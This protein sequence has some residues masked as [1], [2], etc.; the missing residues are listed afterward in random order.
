MTKLKIAIIDLLGLTY[1]GSTLKKRGLGG[2]ES[3]VILMAEQLSGVGFDVTVFNNCIDSEAE[4]GFYLNGLKY[5][6]HGIDT[7]SIPEYIDHS[8]YEDEDCGEEC[9]CFDIVISSRSVH[10]FFPN[11]QYQPLIKK[12]KYK[13]IWMHDTFCEGD[14][15]IENML[16]QGIIDELFTL[17]DFHSTY[18]LNCDHGGKRNFEVMKHK[19]FQTRNGAVK[20]IDEIDLS[21]KDKNHF[22]YNA[23]VT[24]GLNP[25]L[26][27]I[28]PEVKRQIPNAHLTVIGGFYRF[29]EGAEPDAQEK[30]HRRYVETY[31]KELDVTFTGVIPQKEI[32]KILA[33]AGFMLYPTE[34]PETFGISALESLLYKTPLITSRFGALE[35][36][37]LDLAC[38]KQNYA[39]CPNGLFPKI[40][41]QEQ[42]KSFID[43]TI[44]AYHNDYLLQQKQNYCDVIDDI[45]GWD[46]VALQ[47]KQHLY[48]KLK[49]YL[50]VDDYRKVSVINDKVKRIYGRRFENGVERTEYRTTYSEKRIVVVSPFRNADD[51]IYDHCLSIDQQDYDNY[52][53]LL[54]DDNST[55]IVGTPENIKRKIT[56]N[57]ERE[58]CVFNQLSVKDQIKDDDIVMLLDGDDFLVH[59]PTIF[60]YYNQLYHEGIE[61]TY[62]SM[63][64]MVDN[65]PLIAQDYP[66]KVKEEKSYRR[67]LFNWKIP[68]THLRTVLGKHYKELKNIVFQKPGESG[69]GYMKSGADNPLFYELIEKVS[70]EKIKAVKEIMCFY[71]DVN[72]LN[73][74]KV[75]PV[76]QNENAY[77]SYQN[78]EEKEMKKILIAVPT[79]KGIEPETFKSI[80]NLDL[81]SRIMTHFEFF[82]GYQIDQIRNL[83]A[84]W[85]KNYDYV[86]CVDSDMILPQDALI[87]LYEADKDIISAVYMQRKHDEQILEL[88]DENG[89]I[90]SDQ[91]KHGLMQVKGCGFGCVLIKGKVFNEIPYPHFKYKSAL[92]HKFTY[93]EDVYFCDRAKEH[94]FEVWVDT[95]L[96]CGHKGNYEFK[97]QINY[98]ADEE[99]PDAR[100]INYDL[101]EMSKQ[102][103]LPP[104]HKI[105]LNDLK[106]RWNFEPRIIYDIG[107]SCLHWTSVARPIWPGCRFIAFDALE[108]YKD[109][110]EYHGTEYAIAL[111]SDDKNIK[112]FYTNV[113]H[114]AGGSMYIEKNNKELYNDHREM[115]TISLDEL[116]EL[117]DFPFP[118]MIKIDVQGAEKEILK[119]AH[120]TLKSVTHLIIEA[121]SKEYNEGAP[122]KEETFN[123]LD[124]IGFRFVEQI[125]DYGPDA[126]YH[127]IRKN[128]Y[129]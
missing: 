56:R 64:S 104:Y 29:R 39:N 105:Y 124:E 9:N 18:V 27:D 112:T 90:P 35:E 87:K 30:D 50:P 17:S 51:Y 89:N 12:S 31:P 128:L 70:P 117:N 11:N 3:A 109:V 77:T 60:K 19:V 66:Q 100:E 67:H 28:W 44:Q 118:D 52:V 85:G 80:Y 74:F 57:N 26:Q 126:D 102:D 94:G 34:F 41:R 42:A 97:P 76:D 121:Q 49:K 91:L 38:Y 69:H 10:P 111:L 71:N 2:S 58:G 55:N 73:D 36:T 115:G 37:A 116:V 54:I 119:G 14:E 16:N 79:N 1:D 43:M 6:T 15:H 106:N 96:I 4:P 61:F 92:D 108:E 75:N 8:Q 13:I 33:N 68:Y 45:Y 63:W 129:K 107:A 95:T 101:I 82:Y 99:S 122:L 59:N 53:H 86:F 23:S 84:E 81:P 21:K 123:Y 65:I 40:N 125:V 72:P 110:Y 120:K 114:P 48:R 78:R 88:Y 93:S 22:V 103:L 127:F 113:S 47:W 83:I 62:G 46:T 32:A 24:K 98:K 7:S 25:L 20:Y 5:E